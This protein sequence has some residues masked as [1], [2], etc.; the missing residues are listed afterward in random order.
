MSPLPLHFLYCFRSVC[1]SQKFIWQLLQQFNRE[2]A[3]T[4]HASLLP[5]EELHIDTTF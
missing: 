5:Y 4:L 3:K 1:P 2:F